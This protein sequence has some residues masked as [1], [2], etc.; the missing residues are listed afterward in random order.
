MWPNG[1]QILL[2]YEY[3]FGKG[4]KKKKKK[5]IALE[6]CYLYSVCRSREGTSPRRGAAGS[7]DAVGGASFPRRTSQYKLPNQTIRRTSPM[8]LTPTER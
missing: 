7:P 2:K 8:L 3:C 6:H 4:G 1:L 5:N